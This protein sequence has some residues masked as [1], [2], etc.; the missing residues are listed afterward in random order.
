MR[1][2]DFK[3]YLDKDQDNRKD[4]HLNLRTDDI[5]GAK[6]KKWFT[7]IPRG[8]KNRDFFP[9]IPDVNEHYNHASKGLQSS[10]RTLPQQTDF[11]K[12]EY[13]QS[14]MAIASTMKRSGYFPMSEAQRAY[15]PPPP[16][17]LANY[18]DPKLG[19]EPAGILKSSMEEI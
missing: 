11:D 10:M 7:G 8:R 12:D 1:Y 19:M 6:V 14:Q 17:N 5:E 18:A 13:L 4:H 15:R 2:Q 3:Q 16:K 9:D